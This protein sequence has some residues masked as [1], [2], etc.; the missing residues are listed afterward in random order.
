[1]DCALDTLQDVNTYLTEFSK[2][3]LKLRIPLSG[4]F[5]VTY[6]C[7]LRCVHCYLGHLK[8]RQTNDHEMNTERAIGLIDEITDAGCLYLLITG[9]EPLMRD[10]FSAIYRHAKERGLM[11]TVFTNGT[12]ITENILDLFQELP[13]LEV[14]ISLYGASAATYEKITRVPGS[15]QR[16][17]QGINLLLQRGVHVRLKTILMTLNSHEF[18][19]IENMAKKF[20][21]GF[22]F[23]AAIN[24]CLNGDRAPLDLRVAPEEVIDKDFSDSKRA[25]KWVKYSAEFDGP[26]LSDLLYDCGAG[27]IG[28]NIDPYENLQPCMMTTD[29]RHSLSGNNFLVGWHAIMEEIM[30]RKVTKDFSCHGC[31]KGHLC[32]CCPG[33]FKLETGSEQVI[34]PYICA[35][36]DLRLERIRKETKI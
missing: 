8:N 21:V 13:P 16:C 24:P 12:M 6:R 10:D 2:K 19:D 4:S 17:I 5:E 1:M 32:G 34:S 3:A 23:D 15:Y 31:D 30:K 36:G 25:R 9:G 7:N 11:V 20:G 29:I 18:F 14:E 22:R 26:I 33:F 27:M 35:L 28:F